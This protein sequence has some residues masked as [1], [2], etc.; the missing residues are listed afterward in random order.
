LV[1]KKT[2]PK[3]EAVHSKYFE[4]KNYLFPIASGSDFLVE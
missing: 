3:I 2:A 4:L 1:H